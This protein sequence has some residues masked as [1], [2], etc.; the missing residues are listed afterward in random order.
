MKYFKNKSVAVAVMVAAILLSAV[1]GI[2]GRPKVDTPAGGPRLD[3]SLDA[4]FCGQYIVDEADVLV[5]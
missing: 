1:C 5:R 2:T 3:E 4:A